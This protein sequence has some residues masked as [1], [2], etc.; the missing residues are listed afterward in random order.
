MT[1]SSGHIGRCILYIEEITR[2]KKKGES[3]KVETSG[4]PAQKVC[5]GESSRLG[6]DGAALN[7]IGLSI[8]SRLS[9]DATLKASVAGLAVHTS[10]ST[11]GLYVISTGS[12][13]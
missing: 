12:D 2:G 6:L 9:G 5:P 11:R 10:L 7:P 3:S 8:F 1:S 4:I 13:L